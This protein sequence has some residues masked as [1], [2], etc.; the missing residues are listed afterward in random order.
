MRRTTRPELQTERDHLARERDL[1]SLALHC[2]CSE[3]P[4]VVEG[5][6]YQRF[7]DGAPSTEHLYRA[8]VYRAAGAH[9]GIVL[10]SYETAGQSP[11]INVY[12]LEEWYRH[13]HGHGSYA[14]GEGLAIA[15]LAESVYR[16]ASAAVQSK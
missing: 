10:V 5:V 13:T 15:Q 4:D 7:E 14:T 9:G 3:N 16:K 2:K 1:L 12:Y 6:V 8:T 11:S